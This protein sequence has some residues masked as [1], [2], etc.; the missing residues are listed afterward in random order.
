MV[1]KFK[2]GGALINSD[3]D[4]YIQRSADYY[5]LEHLLNM[6][7][8]LVIEPRQQG[9]TSLINALSHRTKSTIT[10][11]VYLDTTTPDRSSEKAWY[12]SL[13]ERMLRQLRPLGINFGVDKPMNHNIWRDFLTNIA[14]S[15]VIE[16][17]RLVIAIDEIGS[18]N[19]PGSTEFFSVLRDIFNSRQ[20][21]PDL[22][23]ITF[24]LVG[25]FHPQ[26]FNIRRTDFTFQHRS[27]S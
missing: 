19:F 9:K 10:Q 15:L 7:Y 23:N 20:F 12:S 26:D 3:A 4:I 22:R 5:I 16:N 21:E 2:A 1:S 17:I 13:S 6:D 11:F 14:N 24:L 27:P 18:V 8:V 25:A